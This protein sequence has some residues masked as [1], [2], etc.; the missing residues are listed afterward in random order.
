MDDFDHSE[1]VRALMSFVVFIGVSTAPCVVAWWREARQFPV[2]VFL[3]IWT[4]LGLCL[5]RFVSGLNL[6]MGPH[7][8]CMA[9]WVLA[10]WRSR[11]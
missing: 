9:A 10:L 11:P 7:M 5:L 6:P 2:I 3:A 4:F 1:R 8:S